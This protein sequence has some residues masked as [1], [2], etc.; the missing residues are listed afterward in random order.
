MKRETAA[1]LGAIA[2]VLVLGAGYLAV[3]VVRVDWLRDYLRVSMA[4]PNSAGLL[5]KSPVLYRGVRVGDVTAVRPAD[6]GVV[7]DLRIEHDYRVP[8]SS[9]V[10][11]EQ[12]SAMGEPYLEFRPDAA[13]GAPYLA[14]GQRVDAKQI[15]TP[16]SIPDMA[17]A[18]T[19]LLQQFDP[20]ALSELID[21]LS[22]GLAGTDRIIPELGRSTGLLAAT[23]LSRSGEMRTLLDQLQRIAADSEWIGPAVAASGPYWGLFGGKVSEVVGVVE[24]VMIRNHEGG[25][26]PEDYVHG[27]GILPFLNRLVDFLHESGPQLQQLAPALRPLAESATA[28]AGRIDLSTLI[29]QALHATTADG[30]L[31]LRIAVK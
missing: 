30:A 4:L 23:L 8:A 27:D 3:G 19:R 24:N 12:L 6:R 14:D 25:T 20:Q 28:A 22:Q 1:S 7:V 9:S 2:T 31:H 10:V 15:R 13:A 5:E 29:S 11:I 18:V 16:V 17:D 26:M 21:T